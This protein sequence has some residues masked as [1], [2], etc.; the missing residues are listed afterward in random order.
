MDPNIILMIIMKYLIQARDEPIRYVEITIKKVISMYILYLRHKKLQEDKKDRTMWVRPT[1]TKKRRLL[2]GANDNLLVEMRLTDSEKYFNNL[3]MLPIIFTELFNIV[4]PLIEK[5]DV[6]R[7][8]I[9]ENQNE[10]RG[11]YKIVSIWR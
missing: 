1:F 8:P 10:I 7:K 2:Q 11:D 9:P 6:V 4:G 5:Q 3:R